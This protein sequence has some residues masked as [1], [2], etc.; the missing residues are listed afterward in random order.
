M[1]LP[2]PTLWLFLLLPAL[3][4]AGEWRAL[5]LTAARQRELV[6]DLSEALRRRWR[7]RLL[8]F[9]LHLD[10]PRVMSDGEAAHLVADGGRL[11]LRR[12]TLGDLP[13]EAEA[14]FGPFALDYAALGVG[15]LEFL[16]P[17]LLAAR[18]RISLEGV[19][20]LLAKSGFEDVGVSYDAARQELELW[21][22]R[23]V[24]F[25]M[26]QFRPSFRVRARILIEGT[27]LGVVDPH[28]DIRGVPRLLARLAGSRVARRLEQRVELEK[29]YRKMAARGVRLAAGVVE[30]VGPEGPIL[31]REIPGDP[32][33]RGQG[34]AMPGG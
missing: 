30:L 24:R 20:K 10:A 4:G 26:F 1:P 5:Q 32:E 31:V 27:H 11:V 18:V 16:Q 13:M 14:A 22:D 15:R 33:V 25:L 2:R 23:P 6:A 7:K 34:P 8:D 19:S 9:D 12:G 21:A 29:D 3:A 28:V 17:A